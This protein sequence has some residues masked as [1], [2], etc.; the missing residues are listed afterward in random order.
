MGRR[1]ATPQGRLRRP[2]DPDRDRPRRRT[3]RRRRPA[4]TES[5]SATATW[6]RR[7]QWG[8]L[9]NPDTD[10]HLPFVRDYLT[11]R[12]I[13]Y[14]ESGR[15]TAHTQIRWATGHGVRR[16]TVTGR[17]LGAGP[18]TLPFTRDD[19]YDADRRKRI[20]RRF[21]HLPRRQ[22]LALLQGLPE[23]D[24]CVSR[25]SE[26]SFTTTSPALAEGIRYQLLRLG[27]LSA[28][29]YRERPTGHEGARADGT[30]IAFGTVTRA[31]DIRV[32]AVPEIA[33][34][35]RVRT[36]DEA[37]LDPLAGLCVLADPRCA[38]H[39]PRR[40]SSSTSRSRGTSRT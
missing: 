24:G 23:T 16:D 11:D 27:V 6:P 19:L 1:R 20:A 37:Q 3:D 36:A 28:G 10:T 9:G 15:G 5:S 17:I 25:G 14:W 12:G 7:R 2:S 31:W 30:R 33:A 22:T 8:Y 18:A 13:H 4:C 40:L 34:L 26:I 39:L 38:C 35:Y 21:A 32:P 29:Q